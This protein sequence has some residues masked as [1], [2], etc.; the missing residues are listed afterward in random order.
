M[1]QEHPPP[2]TPLQISPAL[3]LF[4][5]PS[6]LLFTPLA[7]VPLP[8][9]SPTRCLPCPWGV[10]PASLAPRL[11][12]CPFPPSL[13]LSLPWLCP[14]PLDITPGADLHQSTSPAEMIKPGWGR[15]GV[16]TAAWKFC[17]CE[18]CVPAR[19]GILSEKI[20]GPH[21]LCYNI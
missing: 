13:L 5:P 19:E 17:S 18:V 3:G 4:L 8:L 10:L 1:V 9:R 7:R 16:P 14:Q 2:L 20:P 21:K 11:H 15:L 6:T 12:S